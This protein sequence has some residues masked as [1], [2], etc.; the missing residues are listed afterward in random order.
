MPEGMHGPPP[1]MTPVRD[2][3]IFC[4]CFDEA[5]NEMFDPEQTSTQAV[6]W[7]NCSVAWSG[8]IGDTVKPPYND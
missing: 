3:R 8:I 4:R 7:R 6:W 5:T 2:H 1:G